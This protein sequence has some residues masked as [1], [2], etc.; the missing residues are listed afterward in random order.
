MPTTIAT[1]PTETPTTRNPVAATGAARSPTISPPTRAASRTSGPEAART[2]DGHELAQVGEPLFADA[3]HAAEIGNGFEAAPALPFAQDRGREDR[4]DPG[5][6][7][8]VGLAG[9]VQVERRDRTGR[10]AVSA[11]RS[12][13]DRRGQR[14]TRPAD[15]DTL[16]VGDLGREIQ[17]VQVRI[18]AGTTG[19]V[20]RIDDPCTGRELHDARTRDRAGDVHDELT[21]AGRRRGFGDRGTSRRARRGG[22][23][24]CRIGGRRPV[25]ADAVP[26]QPGHDGDD[27]QCDRAGA[28]VTSETIEPRTQRGPG[29]TAALMTPERETV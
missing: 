7:L 8:Q 24:R 13:V 1:T 14:L 11:S 20:D 26:D 29:P 15:G 18:G 4:A 23:G 12:A 22:V 17:A 16:A 6:L 25:G 3:S 27:E 19:G 21:R 5:Q 9:E 2:S 28:R 10:R